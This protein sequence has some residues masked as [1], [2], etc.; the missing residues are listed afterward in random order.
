MIIKVDG[1]PKCFGSFNRADYSS[2]KLCMEAAKLCR[3]QALLDI[4]N[5]RVILHDLTVQEA[6]DA[7]MELLVTNIR[8]QGKY[9]VIY[10]KLIPEKFRIKPISSVT[11]ADLQMMI[12]EYALTHP[13][14][15]VNRA[16]T[17]LRKMYKAVYLKGIAIVNA[18]EMI[19]IPKS[20]V[21]SEKRDK[22]CT[23]EDLEVFLNALLVYNGTD[24]YSRARNRDIYLMIRIMQHLGLRP[25]EVLG[26]CRE[27]INLE[28]KQLMVRHS[29]GTIGKETRKLIT[30]KTSESMR[31]LPIPPA[32]VQYFIELLEHKSEPLFTDS[33]DGLPYDITNICEV[34]NNVGKKKDIPH[35]TMYM[36]R[37]NFATDLVKMDVKLAQSM[38]GHE[39]AAMTLQY[40]DHASMDEMMDAMKK[41]F[42]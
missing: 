41:R 34:I 3:D 10:K 42:S 40:A 12:N 32:A 30:T 11:A 33:K 37:H 17:L 8:T 27:D 26:L 38:M 15:S 22:F 6:Y 39:S 19:Q 16:G 24:R 18:A 9:K 21:I 4:K 25:Q 36:M 29:V 13:Q 5:N 1:K 28:A 2:D 20:K 23:E 7:S 35:I 31:T 14:D